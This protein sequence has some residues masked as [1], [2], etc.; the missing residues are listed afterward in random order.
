VVNNHSLQWTGPGSC[1][2][3]KLKVGRRGAGR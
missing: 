1:I 2:L 3:V